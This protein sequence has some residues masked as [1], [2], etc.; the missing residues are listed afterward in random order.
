MIIGWSEENPFPMI[1]GSEPPEEPKQVQPKTATTY[2]GTVSG[3]GK[4]GTTPY[5]RVMSIIEEEEHA[6]A[7]KRKHEVEDASKANIGAATDNTV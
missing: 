7:R 1:G 6:E 3:H 2:S 5:D 4:A